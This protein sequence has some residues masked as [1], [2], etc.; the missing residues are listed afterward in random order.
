VSARVLALLVVL[1]LSAWADCASWS[2]KVFP[3]PGT[4]VPTNARFVLQAYGTA[5]PVVA[6]IATRHPRLVT[7]DGSQFPLKV[8]EVNV[9]EFQLTQAVLQPKGA[10]TEGTRYTLRFDQPEGPERFSLPRD[11]SASW[12]V[13][14]ADFEAP[15]WATS[16]S[17]QPG[18]IVQYGCGPLVEARVAV[19]LTSAEPVQFRA[20]VSR[21]DGG[22][23]EFLLAPEKGDI[24]IGH[25]MCSGAFE[26]GEGAWSLELTAV[27]LAGNAT[28][29]PG[30]ALRFKGVES[31]DRPDGG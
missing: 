19:A 16:P 26:P 7:Q 15:V 25:G 4:T 12:I 20:R 10:L 17:A 9:G 13:G 8:L 31:V 11:E 22:V 23:R 3:A 21:P 6:S 2:W 24:A 1:P 29:A 28:R 30:P 5:Q 14:P 18:K 27:D